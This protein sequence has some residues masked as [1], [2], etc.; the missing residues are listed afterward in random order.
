MTRLVSMDIDF[1]N[2]LSVIRG[3]FWN[4][5]ERQIQDL[6]VTP[7]PGASKDLLSRM[8]GAASVKDAL[9]ELA[10]TRYAGLVPQSDDEMDAIATFERSFETAIFGACNNVFTKMFS[11]ATTVGITKLTT[12][13]VQNLAAIA[14]AVEQSIPAETV[15]SKLIVVDKQS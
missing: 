7:T 9:A 4:L 2:I 6:L 8:I 5:D 10:G 14:Y 11:F 1:Y 12:F 15:M 3:R 13:E